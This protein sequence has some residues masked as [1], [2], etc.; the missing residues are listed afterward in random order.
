VIEW[1]TFVEL[2]GIPSWTLVSVVAASLVA[3]GFAAVA[4][5]RLKTR[6]AKAMALAPA[7]LLLANAL[8]LLGF[9]IVGMRRV[10]VAYA[11]SVPAGSCRCTCMPSLP[12]S[13]GEERAL[14]LAAVVLTVAVPALLFAASRIGPGR[15]ALRGLAA[16]GATT[17]AAWSA[18]LFVEPGLARPY[19]CRE[20][21]YEALGD[22]RSLEPL[23]DDGGVAIVVVAVVAA[24]LVLAHRLERGAAITRTW[25]GPVAGLLVFALGATAYQATRPHA[26]DRARRVYLYGSHLGADAPV[27]PDWARAAPR[28]DVGVPVLDVRDGWRLDGREVDAEGLAESLAVYRRNWSILHPGRRWPAELLVY[29]RL[30]QPLTELQEPLGIAHSEAVFD[31]R[32]GFGRPRFSD[33]APELG[34]SGLHRRVSVPFEV[35]PSERPP[36]VPEQ[37]TVATLVFEATRGEPGRLEVHD[38]SVP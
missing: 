18:L 7:T 3:A 2:G 12:P 6:R 22:L 37:T 27:L 35:R 36:P 20:D 29:A 31:F 34:M 33:I 19:R 25:R 16:V 9:W 38:A 1:R 14:V 30:D 17:G 26:R 32:L 5:P 23:F 15:W 4:V 28:S 10:A 24:L 13:L 8:A 11:Q 21:V